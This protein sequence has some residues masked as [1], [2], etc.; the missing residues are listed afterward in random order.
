MWLGEQRGAL[1]DWTTQQ[2]VKATG[3]R[4]T[5]AETP[6]LDGP[7]GKPGGIGGDFFDEWA[8]EHGREL[9]EE[10][11]ARGLLPSL[12]HL[13]GP[14]FVAGA[15]DADVRRFYERTS[16]YELESWAEWSGIFRPF[17]NL[18]AFLF[19]RRL[20][21]LNVPLSPLDTSRGTTSRV[22]H[23][24]RPDTGETEMAG[25]V[26][27]LA[28][29]GNVLY[30]GAY[31]VTTVPG[32]RNPCV[33][34]VFPLPRG[35][36]TVV[37]KPQAGGDGSL[38]VTSS[39]SGF[40]DPGFYFTVHRPGPRVWA[41]YVRTM[42]ETI[43]VYAGGGGEVRADHT[44]WLWGLVFLRLHYRLRPKTPEAAA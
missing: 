19:S 39:G 42:R 10:G 29:T 9:R 31:S 41:R 28:G 3:R 25:W 8:R 26:R 23:V 43:H 37:L 21:Q 6:W 15:V 22:V 27:H 5:L 13:D 20:Q 40:G 32:H 17:G 24:V 36:A 14:E 4:I 44:M 12:S 38:T 35:S 18:L 16:D 34:V 2:W 11:G 1:T 30:A 7:I 33:R